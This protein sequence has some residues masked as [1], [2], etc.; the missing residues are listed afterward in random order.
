MLTTFTVSYLCIEKKC[1]A[2]SMTCFPGTQLIINIPRT[3]FQGLALPFLCKT[4]LKMYSFLPSKPMNI[5]IFG[6]QHAIYL[7]GDS[8]AQDNVFPRFLCI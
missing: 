8:C 7:M 4:Y 5:K 3:E 1:F 6:G 2:L